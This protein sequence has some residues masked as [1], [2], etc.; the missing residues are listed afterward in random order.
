MCLGFESQRGF[1]EP[2]YLGDLDSNRISLLVDQILIWQ[3]TEQVLKSGWRPA[4]ALVVVA[5]PEQTASGQSTRSASISCSKEYRAQVLLIWSSEILAAA[6]ERCSGFRAGS[7]L[8]S[9][10]I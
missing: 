8:D 4:L 6:D 2:K 1:L 5:S 3:L 10:A 7:A 9:F